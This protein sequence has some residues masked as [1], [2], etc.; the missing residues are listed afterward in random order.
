[1]PSNHLILCRPLLQ[2]IF[3]NLSDEAAGNLIDY[4]IWKVQIEKK[5]KWFSSAYKRMIY[6]IT[7][8]HD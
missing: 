7:V 8:G 5:G 3:P 6:Q 4:N 1:M 2:F